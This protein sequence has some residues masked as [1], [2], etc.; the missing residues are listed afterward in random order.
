[1]L[2]K[3]EN[4]FGRKFNRAR[5][6]K[7]E[8][9]LVQMFPSS[10]CCSFVMVVSHAKLVYNL[11]HIWEGFWLDGDAIL[12]TSHIAMMTITRPLMPRGSVEKTLVKKYLYGNIGCNCFA[13]LGSNDCFFKHCQKEQ[14]VFANG[15][16][17]W[18]VT[19]EPTIRKITLTGITYDS[20]FIEDGGT[21]ANGQVKF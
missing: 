1:M 3:K 16:G 9:I 5:L 17:R 14:L 18:C 2:W 8:G 11:C 6:W 10:E 4:F 7:P 12:H 19:N 20:S 13:N 21:V 15:R